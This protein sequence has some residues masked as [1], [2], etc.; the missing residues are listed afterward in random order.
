[1]SPIVSTPRFILCSH[2]P[3]VAYE[4]GLGIALALRERK[5]ALSCCIT[6]S[7]LHSAVTFRRLTKRNVG[8]LDPLSLSPLQMVSALALSSRGA[9][10]VLIIGKPELA[11]L[12]G[13]PIVWI[14]KTAQEKIP[15]GVH[16][17]ILLE[18]KGAP[19]EAP[20]I[21]FLGVLGLD[22][23]LGE[24]A[25]G[26][27]SS[28]SERHSAGVLDMQ[29]LIGLGKS[30]MNSLNLE[31]LESLATKALR[32][33]FP[34]EFSRLHPRL[35]RI[36]VADDSCFN[37][38][39]QTNL[40]LMNFYGAEVVPFSPVADEKLPEK[41]GAV[42]VAGAA[43][44]SYSQELQRNKGMKESLQ[45]FAAKGGTIYS[46]GSG[47]AYLAKSYELDAV[48]YPGIGILPA[49][50]K[51]QAELCT[52]AAVEISEDCVL[53][54]TGV[55][56]KGL[57]LDNWHISGAEMNTL[58]PSSRVSYANGS[59]TFDGFSPFPQIFLSTPYLHFMSAPEVAFSLVQS[60]S[61]FRSTKGADE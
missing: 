8:I 39:Y 24:V 29:R 3:Q 14:Q 6:G 31:L 36:A 45:A 9:D 15:T 30:V 17:L 48:L 2:D 11:Y 34:E 55:T 49:D 13:A 10:L 4:A 19:L 35:V 1:M 56:L 18:G 54:N 37:L 21:P 61:V 25:E 59:P 28:F 42:Y 12:L 41:I 44:T 57:G 53:G 43:L 7:G 52:T 16:G 33:E 51:E 22:T 50:F 47:T 38:T 23:A 5:V 20:A 58:Y 46:E 40:E 60:A 26:K 27:E 32:R